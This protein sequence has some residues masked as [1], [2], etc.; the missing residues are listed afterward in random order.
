MF[1]LLETSSFIQV[2]RWRSLTTSSIMNSVEQNEESTGD[3][4][5]AEEEINSEEEFIKK[6]VDN[7]LRGYHF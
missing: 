4:S 2:L 3:E 5:D 7:N 1:K 6:Y